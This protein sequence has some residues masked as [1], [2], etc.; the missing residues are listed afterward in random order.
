M[1]FCLQ[2]HKMLQ[3]WSDSQKFRNVF[4]ISSQRALLSFS[5]SI[6]WWS[7]RK[8]TALI[9]IPFKAEQSIKLVIWSCRVKNKQCRFREHSWIH[10]QGKKKTHTHTHT[11]VYKYNYSWPKNKMATS[12]IIFWWVTLKLVIW[13]A[14]KPESILYL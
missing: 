11:Y 10:L 8:I 3:F 2:I 9:W 6:V 13:V 14:A 1:L 4:S 7:R 5:N 12:N